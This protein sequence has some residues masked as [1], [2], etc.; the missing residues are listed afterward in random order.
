MAR[1]E[2]WKGSDEASW[3][4]REGNEVARQETWENIEVA[5]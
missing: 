1:C 3:E 5:R 4:I 2:R